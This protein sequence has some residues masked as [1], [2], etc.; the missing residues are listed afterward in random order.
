MRKLRCVAV[1]LLL[2]VPLIALPPNPAAA[3]HDPQHLCEMAPTGAD[4]GLHVMLMALAGMLGMDMNPGTHHQGY[5]PC[6]P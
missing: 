2:V 6:V 3:D 1:I 5:S 4:F